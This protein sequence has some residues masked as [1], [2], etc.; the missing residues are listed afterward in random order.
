MSPSTWEKIANL[1]WSIYLIVIYLGYLSY[2]FTQPRLTDIRKL[3]FTPLVLIVAFL[4][5][6]KH[7]PSMNFLSLAAWTTGLGLGSYLGW[8]AFQSQSLH[9][10]Q[11]KYKILFPANKMIMVLICGGMGL[12][13]YFSQEASATSGKHVLYFSLAAVSL[14]GLFTGYFVG[15]MCSTLR[16]FFSTSPLK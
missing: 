1:H 13:I 4:I 8:A 14:F 12:Q 16:F 2:R 11:Q 10:T 5:T 6:Y 7:N 9:R 3:V 15:R